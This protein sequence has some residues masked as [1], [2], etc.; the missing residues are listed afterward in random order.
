MKKRKIE[1]MDGSNWETPVATLMTKF[2]GKG[3]QETLVK[4]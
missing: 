4:F 1:C 2:L 3:G